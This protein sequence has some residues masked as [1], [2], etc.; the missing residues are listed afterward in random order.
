MKTT[1]TKLLSERRISRIYKKKRRRRT[2]A[3]V[4]VCVCSQKWIICVKWRN[5][6]IVVNVVA[7]VGWRYEWRR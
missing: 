3:R 1:K 2:K 7:I 6:C 5:I 4:C